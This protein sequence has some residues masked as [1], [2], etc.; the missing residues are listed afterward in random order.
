MIPTT[1]DTLRQCHIGAD[2]LSYLS[3]LGLG[4]T[5][6]AVRLLLLAIGVEASSLS[7]EEEAVA[8]IKVAQYLPAIAEAYAAAKKALRVWRSRRGLDT[9]AVY[10]EAKSNCAAVRKKHA[11]AKRALFRV[12]KG[13]GGGRSAQLGVRLDARYSELLTLLETSYGLPFRTLVFRGMRTPNIAARAAELYALPDETRAEVLSV[14]LAEFRD[15][16]AS[17]TSTS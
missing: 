14:L 6:D 1:T 15:L 5:S 2:A 11:E 16:L 9:W 4:S 13:I 12:R 10:Q 3:N 17:G 7:D 8:A